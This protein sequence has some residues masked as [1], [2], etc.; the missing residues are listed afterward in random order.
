MHCTILYYYDIYYI[1]IVFIIFKIND[2]EHL[3][4]IP[5]LFTVTKYDNTYDEYVLQLSTNINVITVLYIVYQC[6]F[7]SLKLY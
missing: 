3:V 1:I 2:Q 6:N 5:N 4:P 7:I